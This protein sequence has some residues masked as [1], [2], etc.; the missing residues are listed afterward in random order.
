MG[1]AAGAILAP[2]VAG[3]MFGAR[4]WWVGIGCGLVATLWLMLWLPRAAHRHFE[5]A[6]FGKA[7]RR[8]RFI[9][10]IAFTRRRERAAILSRAG[11]HLALGRI[12]A[13][14]EALASID[15]AVLDTSERVVWLNNRACLALARPGATDALAL[16]EEATALRPDVPA[17]Q[18][19]RAMALLEVGRIDD[20]ITVLDAMRTAG[21]LP[22][23]LEGERCRELARA[24]EQK[25]QGAYAAD[26]R[27]RAR[28]HAVAS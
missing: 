8:Y 22:P 27:E 20:A 13:A 2:V 19:T 7:A 4:W 18:H 11:C 16:V 28:L 3:S 12:P 6:R 15:P 21:E 26:Y 5:A 1:W 24:W 25:G 17:I 10:S 23:Q 9:G 14:A